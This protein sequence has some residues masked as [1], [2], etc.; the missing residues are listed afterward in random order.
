MK[1]LILIVLFNSLFFIQVK[2][3]NPIFFGGSTNINGGS[4]IFS[5][6]QINNKSALI[7]SYYQKNVFSLDLLYK[8]FVISNGFT[9]YNNKNKN[10]LTI[11][12][13]PKIFS[14]NEKWKIFGKI[15]INLNKPF[16]KFNINEIS[17]IFGIG[18]RWN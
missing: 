13:T 16:N 12:Y 4:N 18:L 5:G 8:G 2:A 11:L 10:F 15:G 1:K 9:L 17:S 7:I 14:I 6:Y 3:Q